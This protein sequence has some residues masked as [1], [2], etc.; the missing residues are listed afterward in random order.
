MPTEALP[1]GPLPAD[2]LRQAPDMLRAVAYQV[3]QSLLAWIKLKPD[4]VLYLEGAED[5]DLVGTSG[6]EA[7]QVYDTTRRVSLRTPKLQD[8]IKNYWRLYNENAG[9]PVRLRFLSRAHPA[10]EQG[11]PF[12][13]GTAGLE[14]WQRRYLD[15][16][17]IRLLTAFLHVQP[18]LPDT[19]KSFLKDSSPDHLRENFF[20]RIAWDLGNPDASALDQVVQDNLAV[21]G[22]RLGLSVF[23]GGQ[24]APPLLCRSIRGRRPTA[25]SRSIDPRQ[26]FEIAGRRG[27]RKNFS[28]G[29]RCSPQ[30]KCRTRTW[31]DQFGSNIE[32]VASRVAPVSRCHRNAG[33]FS[34]PAS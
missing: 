29:P 19:L 10:V 9:V 20:S 8:A 6:A 5:F 21:L 33:R 25:K 2:P 17:E 14:L 34:Q 3:R 22:E 18:S 12:G 7:V 16:D 26:P 23:G 24:D 13:A 32:R 28:F 30:P 1:P 31:A 4:E 27:A 15:D 11:E